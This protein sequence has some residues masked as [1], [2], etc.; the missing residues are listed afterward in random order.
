MSDINNNCYWCGEKA[1]S[2]ERVLP[3]S[4]FPERKYIEYIIDKDF[5]R[6]LITVP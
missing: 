6:D 2:S 3:K 5:R 1:T 4:L